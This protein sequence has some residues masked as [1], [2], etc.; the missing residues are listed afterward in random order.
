MSNTQSNHLLTIRLG[1]CC[2]GVSFAH[3]EL[4]DRFKNFISQ[5]NHAV[6][7]IEC[8]EYE[9][10][11]YLNQFTSSHW[12]AYAEFKCLLNLASDA[13]M[14]EDQLIFHSVS[15]LI[16]NHVWLLSGPSGIGKST[17]YRNLK[18]MY[19][20]Q[21]EIISGDNSVLSFD[22]YG[23]TVYPSPWNGKED[24]GS[25]K[26]GKLAGIILLE[27]AK[28]NRIT[29]LV[30]SEA[31]IP[32]FQQINTY[33]KTSEQVYKLAGLEQRLLE[34]IPVIKFENTGNPDSSK[35]LYEYI[36]AHIGSTI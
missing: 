29:E 26:T 20:D 7:I 8:G 21:V 13:M 36:D 25:M 22:D 19:P 34:C 12:D 6:K 16:S 10:K 14:F 35:M 18:Q 30:C 27:Q 5:A 32:V 4:A 11:Q 2:L 9:K 15:L 1:S 23:V 31:V 28:Q 24:W 17:Q 3:S 33:A